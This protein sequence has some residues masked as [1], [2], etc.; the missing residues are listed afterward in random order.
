MINIFMREGGRLLIWKAKIRLEIL[1]GRAG[2]W[3]GGGTVGRGLR[4]ETI[5]AK[6]KGFVTAPGEMEV[7]GGGAL[8]KYLK[9]GGGEVEKTK[10][11][12]RGLGA[13][14]GEQGL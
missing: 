4:W 14:K 10:N 3:Q 6:N 11:D 2:P 5:P 13:C 8:T 12:G 9:N 7:R 1:K